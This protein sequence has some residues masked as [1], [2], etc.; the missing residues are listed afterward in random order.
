M[1]AL[2]L[3]AAAL[4]LCAQDALV[5]RG[6][7]VFQ[8]SCSVPYCHGPNGTAGRAPKLVGHSFTA[9]ELSNI[10]SDGIANKGMPAFGAQLPA[11]DIRA[12]VGYI[13]TLR[14]S[15]PASASQTVAARTVPEDAQS[16]K[17][18]FFDAVR[19]GGCGR[20]HELEK[21]GSRVATDLKTAAAHTDLRSIEVHHVMT[22][23]PA[24]ESAFPVLVAEQSQKRVRVF[25]LSSPL[26]VLRTFAPD[27]VKLTAGSAWEHR[28]AVSGYSDAELQEIAKYLQWVAAAK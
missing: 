10:V 28:E 11:D 26:P 9:R 6:E 7:K 3:L 21:R 1:R 13:M 15:A 20:C 14:G 23:Q 2:L 5:A 18:L 24:G 8:T 27:A 19:M 16:G 4:P 17:A 12:V 22:A 25:D